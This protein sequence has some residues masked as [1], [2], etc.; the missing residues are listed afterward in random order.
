M[1]DG[2]YS[3]PLSPTRSSADGPMD[4][5]AIAEDHDGED[6]RAESEPLE[7]GS[8]KEKSGKKRTWGSMKDRLKGVTTKVTRRT[9]RKGSG[10]GEKSR[11]Q[12]KDSDSDDPVLS[13]PTKSVNHTSYSKGKGKN[14]SPVSETSSTPSIPR[15]EDKSSPSREGKT[16]QVVGL[17]LNPSMVVG[18]V[19]LGVAIFRVTSG[20]SAGSSGVD[21]SGTSS[22]A[23][24]PIYMFGGM[25]V[26]V[27]V[28]LLGTWF[29]GK[30]QNNI[31]YSKNGRHQG[32][33]MDEAESAEPGR[34]ERSADQARKRSPEDVDQED[35]LLQDAQEQVKELFPHRH[36]QS[37][38]FTVFYDLLHAP[39]Q[40]PDPE[41][42]Q[43]LR[44]LERKEWGTNYRSKHKAAFESMREVAVQLFADY[45][46]VQDRGAYLSGEL[47]RVEV[48]S[49]HAAIRISAFP[50]ENLDVNADMSREK[51]NR[52]RGLQTIRQLPD[53][54]SQLFPDQEMPPIDIVACRPPAD[55][56]VRQFQFLRE[57][58]KAP[59]QLD[60]RARKR[61]QGFKE[62]WLSCKSRGLPLSGV[63]RLADGV[64]DDTRA[65][66][67]HDLFELTEPTRIVIDYLPH[68]HRQAEALGWANTSTPTQ[69]RRASC[70]SDVAKA[71]AAYTQN[72]RLDILDL[73]P[74]MPMEHRS[75]EASRTGD[76]SF[77]FSKTRVG[78][79]RI[80]LD[81]CP[82]STQGDGV[83]E[84][85]CLAAT[86]CDRT[87]GM[88]PMF[89]GD[90]PAWLVPHVGSDKQKT[91]FKDTVEGLLFARSTKSFRV[92]QLLA[93]M[94]RACSTTEASASSNR[95]WSD[96][97]IR[98][99]E[100]L[101]DSTG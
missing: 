45:L 64:R 55:F 43:R 96:A 18:V 94:S 76:M 14:N 13:S 90:T 27:V 31:N 77:A 93:L 23:T 51:A 25:A 6:E 7:A 56:D 10:G 62:K 85:E 32:T 21:T 54:W 61:Y 28:V 74:C 89:T 86:L 80:A 69:L 41:S 11:G 36:M 5:D 12:S 91:D 58:A 15:L 92:K 44:E 46:Q 65:Y 38:A 42:L 8:A 49:D 52:Q 100:S 60:M 3:A 82:D 101:L 57:C 30:P 72:N 20:F 24:T 33:A 97:E 35:K 48:M 70:F 1:A 47:L 87:K 78:I 53:E 88:L 34:A 19:L 84:V 63:R 73:G 16:F 67:I 95:L 83:S 68:R 75:S 59:R 66:M 50:G 39:W 22:A 37:A 26:L 71:C 81:D 17:D 99:L 98:E 2:S 4:E 29:K 79:L 40:D 9:K